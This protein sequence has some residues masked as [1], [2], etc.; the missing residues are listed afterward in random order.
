MKRLFL[1]V[2]LFIVATI[3]VHAQLLYKI[4]GK[5]LK[6]PSYI[7]GTYHLAPHTFIDSIPGLNN[8]YGDIKQVYGEVVTSEMM[9][10]ENMQKMMQMMQ[11]PDGKTLYDIYTKEEIAEIDE[12]VTKVI[13]FSLKNPMVEQQLIKLTPQTLTTQLTAVAAMKMNS[14]LDITK[15]I[16]MQ[17]QNMAVEK[18]MKVGGLETIE[19][20]MKILYGVPMEKGKKS[21]LCFVRNFEAGMAQSEHL[22]KA[23]KAQDIKE[24]EAAMNEKLNNSCDPTEE[25]MNTLLYNRNNNWIKEMPEIMTSAPTLFAVG[26]GHLIGDKGVLTLLKNAGYK[27]EAVTK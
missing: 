11:M 12:V 1:L 7:V 21:L 13:G 26:A 20:Q 10:P 23:Y 22:D 5:N 4:S 2:A 19:S 18:G 24:V 14:G 16:D 6:S 25:E 15:P 3:G 27:V 9:K 17:I 8:V